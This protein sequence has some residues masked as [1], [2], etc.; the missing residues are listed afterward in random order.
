MSED[1]FKNY[2]ALQ[3]IVE[4]IVIDDKYKVYTSGLP[5]CGPLFPFIIRIMKGFDTDSNLLN[6][7]EKT[8]T[9]YHRLTETFK[10]AFA[11]RALLGDDCENQDI[12]Q[13]LEDIDNQDFIREV[14]SKIK[15]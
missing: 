12:K 6:D 15:D 2:Q 1:D 11:K 13:V 4:P 3:S 7:K 10:H 14:I 5:S 8:T 9:F